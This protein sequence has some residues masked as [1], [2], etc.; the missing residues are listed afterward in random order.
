MGSDTTKA[1]VTTHA[2]N[3]VRVGT[4]TDLDEGEVF[5]QENG[6]THEALTTVALGIPMGAFQ[7]T[8]V[9]PGT[10]LSSRL[11]N[12]RTIVMFVYLF[13]T[14]IGACLLWQFPTKL[15]K[16]AYSLETIS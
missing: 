15:T 4:I 12:F 9:L 7:I 5:L 2:A 14:I 1:S 16:S 10:Y 11:R 3:A 8:F 13:P 6:L